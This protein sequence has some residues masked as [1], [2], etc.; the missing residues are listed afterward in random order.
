MKR[1]ARL[2]TI[3]TR[4][5]AALVT[6]AIALGAVER[7]VAY[8]NQYPG[9]WG[10]TLA[11]ACCGVVFIAGAKLF[12][13]VKPPAPSIATGPHMAPVRRHDLPPR[14]REFSDTRRTASRRPRAASRR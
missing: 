10:L 3:K 7:A 5:E 13:A 11:L 1:L 14:R 6:Y 2:F 12:D 9:G 4:F 8:L